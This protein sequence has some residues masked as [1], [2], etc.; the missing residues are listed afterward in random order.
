MSTTLYRKYRPKNFDEVIGQAHVVRTLSNAIQNNRL[1][2]AYL[3]TGPRGTG[4]T[5][6][7]RILAKAVNCE[8]PNNAISCEE[9]VACKHINGNQTLDIIEIDAASNTGV[10]NIRE[11]RQTVALPPTL[12]KYKV[13]ILDEVHM[14]STGAFNALLKTVEEPPAHVVFIMATT[15]QNKVPPTILSRSQC[16]RFRPISETD[17]M[18]RLKIVTEAEKMKVEPEALRLIAR[19]A[20]GALRDALTM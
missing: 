6:I 15:E 20:G 10:D 16:F 18:A 7:A 3:F 11:L 17:I 5:S 9:C 1:G 4:K 2:Q 14:L 13:Y 8:K 12:L 19:S